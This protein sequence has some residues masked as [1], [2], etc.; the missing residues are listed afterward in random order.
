MPRR[1]LVRQN[2]YP[3]HIITR[4]N[5]KKFFEVALFKMWEILKDAL[6]VSLERVPVEIH[7]FVLMGNHYHLLVTTP[8]SDIDRFMMILNKRL[9]DMIYK[10]RNSKV[11][12][13]KFS[14]RYKWSIVDNMN[15]IFNIYRYIYQNPIR[16][17]IASKCLDYPYSSLRL[18][19]F[20]FKKLKITT[21]INYYKYRK[22]MDSM[23]GAEF[24]EQV[25]K[26]LK[27]EV[28]KVSNSTRV[29]IIKKLNEGLAHK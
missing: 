6:Q 29:E 15:Y 1:K 5:N 27:K 3:Y 7:C 24:D 20:E 21:H 16:A 17:N 9:S 4:S 25:R 14:N 11:I 8:N 23:P 13:H 19:P 18:S 10:H 22:W 28:F 26:G 2:S 12:N